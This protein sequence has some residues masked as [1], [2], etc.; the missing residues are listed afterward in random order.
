M[1]FAALTSC[2]ELPRHSSWGIIA[3]MSGLEEKLAALELAHDAGALTDEI[4]EAECARVREEMSG[5]DA[6]PQEPEP[7]S[8]AEAAEP[9]PEPEAEATPPEG[10]PPEPEPDDGAAEVAAEAAAAEAEAAEARAAAAQQKAEADAA[11]AA[12][13]E[14]LKA[15]E[16]QANMAQI[17]ALS[18]RFTGK[19]AKAYAKDL[20]SSMDR[21]LIRQGVLRKQ[22]DV[23]I[24]PRYFFLFN[25]MMLFCRFNEKKGKETTYEPRKQLSADKLAHSTLKVLAAEPDLKDRELAFEMKTPGYDTVLYAAT[26]EEREEWVLELKKMLTDLRESPAAT[27]YGT[28]H[29]LIEGT[30]HHAALIGDVALAQRCIAPPREAGLLDQVDDH[31]ATALHVACFSGKEGVAAALVQAGADASILDAAGR[32]AVHVAA[33]G[34]HVDVISDAF[35]DGVELD[36]ADDAD[37]TP[38]QHALGSN[39]MGVASMLVAMGAEPNR[40]NKGGWTGVHIAAQAG[41]ADKV[42]QWVAVGADCNTPVSCAGSKHD[43]FTALL[44]AARAPADAAEATITVLLENGADPNAT[45]PSGGLSALQLALQVDNTTVAEFLVRRGASYE[46]FA[47]EL[48][49]GMQARFEELHQ[50]YLA[51]EERKRMLAASMA[52]PAGAQK[53]A[54]DSVVSGYAF[55]SGSTKWNRRFLVVTKEER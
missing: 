28:L 55:V 37:T 51:A 50:E 22:G 10:V 43:G 15:A 44:L 1:S 18:Q 21:R 41:E 46:G 11:A 12:E 24:S 36:V 27:A 14:A 23:K 6:A 40:R 5:G 25:D 45:E 34:G 30:L 2:S 9:E 16:Q 38:L 29:Q 7:Q 32:S 39:N 48:D 47:A 31:G 49:E 19:E 53:M 35:A 4:Y 17:A 3:E 20:T 33:L 13:A 52:A 42:R 54:R 26:R 8:E